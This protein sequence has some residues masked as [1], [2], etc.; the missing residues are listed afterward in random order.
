MMRCSHIDDYIE[1]QE[2]LSPLTREMLEFFQLQKLNEMLARMCAHG[3]EG[4]PKKIDSLEMLASLPF[5]TAAALAAHPARYLLSSQAEVAR[6]I[7]DQTSGTTS[8]SKRVFYTEEDVMHTVDFF[9]AGISEMVQPGEAVLITMPFSGT[10]GLGDLIKRAVEKIGARPLCIGW[11]KDYATLADCVTREKPLAYIGFPVPLLSLARAMGE[12][13]TIKRALIS[14]DSCPT[15]VFELLSAQFTMYPHYGSRE[16][17]MGGAIT[18]P[19]FD[20]M[21]VRENHFIVE[22]VDADGNVVPDGEEGEMVITT[23][24]MKAMPLLRYRTGDRTRILSGDCLCGSVTK[25]IAQSFRVGEAATMLER[26]DSAIFRLPEVVDAHAQYV[27]GVLHVKALCKGECAAALD[28]TVRA[29]VPEAVTET[30]PYHDSA[31]PLYPGK[32]ILK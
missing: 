1:K 12:A 11:G 3:V 25:R 30:L 24:G 22:I 2:G 21:H 13:C 10:F 4:I 16:I 27:A 6:I 19:A 32:R 8:A 17:C 5:T 15:G 29:I 26:L 14:G 28:A 20:G 31:L 18:C 23:I 9:A 7:T